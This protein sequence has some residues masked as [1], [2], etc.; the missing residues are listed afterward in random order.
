MKSKIFKII[1][2]SLLFL[3]L[4]LGMG[5]GMVLSTYNA[6]TGNTDFNFVVAIAIV[7]SG[8]IMCLAFYGIACILEYLEKLG[9]NK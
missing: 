5:A 1:S 6:V 3:N 2:I 4:I 9:A 7:L 8:I